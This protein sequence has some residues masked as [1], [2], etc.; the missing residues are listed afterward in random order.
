MLVSSPLCPRRRCLPRRCR[1]AWTRRTAV[2]R[3]H[4]CKPAVCVRSPGGKCPPPTAVPVRRRMR[5]I[6]KAIALSQTHPGQPARLDRVLSGLHGPA[7]RLADG[8][9]CAS[10]G[11]G[12]PG[13]QLGQETRK[14][15]TKARVCN[16]ST[17]RHKE[18]RVCRLTAYVRRHCKLFTLS[19]ISRL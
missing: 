6:K 4:L 12:L 16:G 14:A 2:R 8:R 15:V 10:G 9:T 11:Y 5:W 18:D 17:R 1:L 19:N 3:A 13:T 7:L